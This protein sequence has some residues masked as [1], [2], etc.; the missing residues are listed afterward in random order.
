M[1]EK[2][3]IPG[4]IDAAVAGVIVSLAGYAG[5]AYFGFAA[6]KY[7][8]AIGVLIAVSGVLKVAYD[9]ATGFENQR[10]LFK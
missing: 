10:R 3:I 2:Y 1:T 8:I 4:S 9:M 5:Q 6:A 7:V